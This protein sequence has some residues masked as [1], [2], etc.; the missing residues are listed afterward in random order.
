LFCFESEQTYEEAEDSDFETFE[1][2]SS[3]DREV[4]E[5]QDDVLNL[6]FANTVVS[7]TNTDDSDVEFDNDDVP[8][9]N[10]LFSSVEKLTIKLGKK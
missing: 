4:N 7:K 9:Q 3:V 1:D 6:K 5:I 2:Y 8:D 10:D